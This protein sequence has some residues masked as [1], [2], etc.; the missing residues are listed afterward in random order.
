MEN[1][2]TRFPTLLLEI[3]QHRYELQCAVMEKNTAV[4]HQ[5][6]ELGATFRAKQNEIND[7]LSAIK[8]ELMFGYGR[9]SFLPKHL[10]E[11]VH[12]HRLL[13]E[14]ESGDPS[15]TLKLTALHD[16]LDAAKLD[17]VNHDQKE[18]EAWLS[19]ELIL[20]KKALEEHGRLKR[21]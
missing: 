10:L 18:R 12:I 20:V 9:L 15:L 6:Y 5:K 21:K 17:A 1:Y 3:L 14:L 7:R 19:E 13:A 4:L 16:Y 11:L 8:E 2:V